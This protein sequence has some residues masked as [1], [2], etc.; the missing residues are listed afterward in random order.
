MSRQQTLQVNPKDV[1]TIANAVTI[2]GLAVTCFG[3]F[4]LDSWLGFAAIAM[5]R[6]LDMLD[7]VIA[8]KTRTSPFG[9]LLDAVSDKLAGLAIVIGALYYQLVPRWL[10][11]FLVAQ[12]LIVVGI[13][14]YGRR[15]GRPTKVTQM[16]KNNMFLH[17]FTLIV[18][19][20]AGLSEGT[21]GSFL[22][23]VAYILAVSS[24][25][26]G[27]LTTRSYYSQVK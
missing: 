11:A 14:I 21:A 3:S 27:I 19:A 9:A 7:G 13:A 18:F 20:G 17:M 15:K 6:L 16:G 8:R 24:V 4:K 22:T 12:H 5:G 2:I 1:F 26:H 23:I 10:I 25:T